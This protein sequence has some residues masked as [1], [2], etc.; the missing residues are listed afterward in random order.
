MNESQLMYIKKVRNFF[1]FF[2]IPSDVCVFI[3]CQ[4]ALESNF[5]SSKLALE[6]F[7]HCGMKN[8]MVRISSAVHAGDADF[9]WA[10]YSNYQLC[11]MDYLLCIQ[12]HRP[13]SVDYDTPVHFARFIAKFYCPEKDYID[14]IFKIY[15]QFKSLEN[16][17]N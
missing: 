5:G 4:F 1:Q 12:Y 8:P 9:H 3:A 11:C 7:N 2:N 10:N 6:N 14:K 17:K 13:L 16:G 15:N